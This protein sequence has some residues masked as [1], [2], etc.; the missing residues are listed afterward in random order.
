MNLH[1]WLTE[2]AISGRVM[3]RYCIAPTRLRYEVGSSIGVPASADRCDPGI[4]GVETGF[5]PIMLN[6]ASRSNDYFFWVIIVDVAVVFISR[7][8]KKERY[9]RS[10]HLNSRQTS[11]MNVF[12]SVSQSPVITKSSTYMR[13]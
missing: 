5:E 1:T 8:R 13:T 2:K 7:P 9:P 10:L 3:L 12:T 11:L 4:D 6:L